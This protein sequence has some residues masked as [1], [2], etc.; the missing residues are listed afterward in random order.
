V[1]FWL[2]SLRL[3]YVLLRY[4]MSSLFSAIVDNAVFLIAFAATSS[5]LGAQAL[6]RCASVG[7]NFSLN[8]TQVFHSHASGPGAFARYLAL[9]AGSG[10]AS[11]G[12]I[13]VLVAAGAPVL[14]SKLAAESLLFFG[15]FAVQ[16]ARI[17]P[18][19]RSAPSPST[20]GAA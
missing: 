14:P 3:R 7:L 16:R 9:V 10:A 18:S 1:R 12:L 11:Y 6:G 13:R 4:S 20:R 15:N 17:F 19:D 8:R 5:I 2:E